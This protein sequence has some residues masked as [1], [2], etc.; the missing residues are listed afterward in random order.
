MTKI[1]KTFKSDVFYPLNTWNETKQLFRELEV[2][3]EIPNLG[4]VIQEDE[5]VNISFHVYELNNC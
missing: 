1:H 5:N 2:C 3:D 4:Q